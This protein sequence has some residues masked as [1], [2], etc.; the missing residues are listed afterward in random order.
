MINHKGFLRCCVC[1][2]CYDLECAGVSEQRFG[3][4][5][6]DEHRVAWICVFCVSKL[7][8][9]KIS[10]T[11]V[12]ACSGGITI[13]RGTSV[14]SPLEQMEES[15]VVLITPI[16]Q[17]NEPFYTGTEI[18]DLQMLIEV[19]HLLRE[20]TIMMQHQMRLLTD[21]MA[22]LT[23]K[24]DICESHF[25]SLYERVALE[26]RAGGGF[27][28]ENN[29][30]LRAAIEQLKLELND[31]DQHPLANDVDIGCV[32]ELTEE[33]LP[34][35]AT[36]LPTKLGMN[37]TESDYVSVSR[38]GRVFG[39]ENDPAPPC[40]R[41]IVVRFARRTIRDLMLRKAWKRRRA[42]TAV[43]RGL[44]GPPR[45]N[46]ANE[47]LTKINRQLLRRRRQLGEERK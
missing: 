33:N 45:R 43:G 26:G 2:Q 40:P 47:R 13:T 10:S 23:A 27:G 15:I 24:I 37:L 22:I 18:T 6:I 32:P 44:L 3:N 31:R 35:V 34:H 38:V 14:P 4:T 36:T 9:A 5:L 20:E 8:K 42:T 12:R 16:K 46:Y 39:V 25:E 30:Q 21:T 17:K 41:L 1:G 28:A 7:P 11:P 19:V 29:N